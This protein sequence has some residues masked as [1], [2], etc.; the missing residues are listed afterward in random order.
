[1]KQ[2]DQRN[3]AGFRRRSDFQIPYLRIIKRPVDYIHNR[4]RPGRVAIARQRG[5]RIVWMDKENNVRRL[6]I[7]YLRQIFR[8][9]R[10]R[11]FDG[12]STVHDDT[13]L[14]EEAYLLRR[15]FKHI[16][17]FGIVAERDKPRRRIVFRR[18]DKAETVP[19]RHAAISEDDGVIKLRRA[20]IIFL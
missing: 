3:R 14:R 7:F 20:R 2:N 13:T 16:I 11:H 9:I 8:L 17:L 15:K 10:R 1:M 5:R 4:I 18:R 12:R 6:R 19:A